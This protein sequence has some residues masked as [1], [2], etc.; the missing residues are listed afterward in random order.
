MSE[1][2]ADDRLE[3]TND[4]FGGLVIKKKKVDGDEKPEPSGKSLLGLDKL[5]STKREHARKRLAEDE[6]ND[7]GV[8]ESVRRGIEKVHEKHRDRDRESRG[9]KYKSR[10]EDR[11]D[12]DRD[13]SDRRDRDRDRDRSH[14]RDWDETPRF[15]VPETPSR[16]SWDDD[17]HAS[18]SHKKNSWDMPTPRGDR[19]RDRKR[20]WGSERSISS[21]YRSERRHQE[22]RNQRRRH[23]PEDSV[24][25]EKD[26]KPE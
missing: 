7:R 20:D 13:R 14:R 5:A 8:T 11:R 16:I 12:R 15:K 17:R 18:S 26:E 6:D 1:K 22:E 19:D 9:M 21:A 3:G 2:R 25:S 10:D 24:R 4:T 23:R